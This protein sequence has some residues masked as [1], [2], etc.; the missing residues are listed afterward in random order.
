ME[1]CKEIDVEDVDQ[2]ERDLGGVGMLAVDAVDVVGK[3]KG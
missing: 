2:A 3:V 1:S